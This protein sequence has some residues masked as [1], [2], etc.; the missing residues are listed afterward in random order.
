MPLC[1]SVRSLVHFHVLMIKSQSVGLGYSM[2]SWLCTSPPRAPTR[3][4]LSK[5]RRATPQRVPSAS[6][7][8]EAVFSVF[9]FACE[10]IGL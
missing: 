9:L 4:A 6:V 10:N 2:L 8:G 5:G 3:L 1:L 7:G